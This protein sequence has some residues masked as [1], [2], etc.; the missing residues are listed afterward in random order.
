MGNEAMTE[1]GD[2]PGH[3]GTPSPLSTCWSL[4]R[5][6][7]GGRTSDREAFGVRY[8]APIRAFLGARWRRSALGAEVDDAVQEVFFECFRDGGVLQRVDEGRP[9]GFRAFLYGV[10][11]NVALRCEE[12]R[13]RTRELPAGE[14]VDLDG[15][16]RDEASLEEAFDRG[17]ALAL[18]AEA[19]EL[20]SDRAEQRG[21]E[22]R[23]RVEILRLHFQEGVPV[24]EIA[25]RLGL[26]RAA[27]WREHRAA[28]EE[29]R[30]ALHAVVGFHHPG[31][32]GEVDRECARLTDLMGRD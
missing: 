5:G 30:D 23:R 25:R 29:F 10:A 3:A 16:E 17:W 19:R 9:G 27:A 22:A 12:R 26:D 2:G 7:A 28:R 13:A 18:V 21:P 14:E 6:A 11:R 20:Q 1:G 24:H 8:A 32:P 15:I 4:I 31:T